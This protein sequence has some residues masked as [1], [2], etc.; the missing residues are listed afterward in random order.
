MSLSVCIGVRR[1][2][3]GRWERRAPIVPSDVIELRQRYGIAVHVQPSPVRIFPESAYLQAGATVGESLAACPVVFGVK[4]IP[5]QYLE[6]DKTYVFFAHVIKGQPHNMPMLRRLM[7]LGCN[8]IDYERIADEHGR[9]LIFFGRHAGIAGALETLWALGRRLAWEGVANPFV[10]LRHAYEYHDLAEIKQAVAQVGEAIRAEGLPQAIVPVIIGVTGYGNVAR[11]VWE[12]LSQ[13]PVRSVEPGE[14]PALGAKDTDR[15]AV[16]AATFREEHTVAPVSEGDAFDLGDYYARP[17]RYRG[18]FELY[19]PSLTAIV[20]AVYWDARY[21]RLVTKA[22]LRELFGR[23]R[24]RLRV[25]GDISCDIEGSIECTVRA[26]E[27]D[28]P[29]YVYNPST[30]DTVDGVAGDG[31]VVMAVDILPSE[32]PRD[33]SAEFSRA[34]VPYVPAIARADYARPF[35]RLDLPPEIKRA[36]I[37]HRGALTPDYRYLAEF[38][39]REAP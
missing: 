8:L 33:A 22:Y 28:E 14:I 37:V 38:V 32:L 26:T 7:E 34:L 5:A 2:D 3:K 36:L 10:A 19:V 15:H 31:V 21:P 24:P 39:A 27:P 16:Y 30:G 13:L 1:E 12:V 4:E 18:V 17:A 6:R 29:V 35:D 9:R 20:N 11:G 23:V 25:I